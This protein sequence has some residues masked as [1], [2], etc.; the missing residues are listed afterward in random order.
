MS[1][2]TE[3]ATG[4]V[5]APAPEAAKEVIDKKEPVV[6]KMETDAD[7]K[8]EVPTAAPAV[9]KE[10][11]EAKRPREEEGEAAAEPA[12]KKATPNKVRRAPPH[13][14]RALARA[15]RNPIRRPTA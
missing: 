5:M 8:E 9:E 15:R 14:T 11:E 1:A 7:K 13:R 6:E 3:N 4:N 10:G 12:A 2:A